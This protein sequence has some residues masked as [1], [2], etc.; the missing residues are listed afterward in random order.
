MTG[1]FVE[2]VAMMNPGFGE[3]TAWARHRQDE[4]YTVVGVGD[5]IAPFGHPYPHLWVTLT[6]LAAA[7][8]QLRVFSTFA[9]NLLRSPVEFAE[10]S[11]SLAAASGGRF[12]AG[13]GAG[14]AGAELNSMGWPLPDGPSRARR[15]CE[16]MQIVR[17]LFDER[18]CDFEG[19]HYQI[20][21]ATIGVESDHTP[22]LVAAV[23]GPWT[24][25][26]VS[27]YADIVELMPAA[28]SFRSGQFDRNVWTAGGADGCERML[29]RARAANPTARLGLNLPI[30]IGSTDRI[31]ADAAKFANGP[32]AGMYGEPQRVADR[33]AQLTA[34]GATRFSLSGSPHDYAALAPHLP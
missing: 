22:P 25:D 7:C 34:L 17:A 14:W 4:G 15:Y 29:E 30:S 32:M 12:D 26:N 28:N 8:P 27:P 11:L 19:E 13:L 5:H 24:I 31:K 1:G 9:N 10:A 21:Q 18:R 23:G 6:S 20:H 2:Y 16:A 33:I 3:P